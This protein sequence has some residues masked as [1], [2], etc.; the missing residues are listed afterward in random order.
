MTQF[1]IGRPSK[2]DKAMLALADDR[3]TIRANFILDKAFHKQM[4]QFA[5]DTNITMTQ[6][7][8]EAVS[9][10]IRKYENK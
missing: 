10:Y 9:E 2:K 5:L 1:R 4:K 7:I 6:L 3:E 8:K